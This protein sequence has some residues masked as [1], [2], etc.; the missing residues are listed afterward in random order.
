MK[1]FTLAVCIA[2][3]C[4]ASDASAQDRTLVLQG[5]T[6]I[7]GTGRAP[8]TDA[9]VVVENGRI[10]SVGRRGQM[11]IPAG[12]QIIDTTGQTILPG[13]VD[14]HLHLR[15]WKIPF[16]PLYGVV[17]TGDIHNDTQWILGQKALLKSGFMKGPRLF[18]SGARING[19]NG[20]PLK[21]STGKIV[22]DPS[23]VKTPDEARA[24]VRYLH[25]AGVDFLKVDYS[26]TEDQLKAIIDEASKYNLPVLGH[27]NNVDTAMNYGGKEIEHMAGIFRAQMIREG[28]TP[29]ASNG[30]ALAAGVDP[31]KF[32]PLIQRMVEQNVALDIALYWTVKP[33]VWDIMRPEVA[34]L[35]NDPA[36]AFV[37]AEE[38]KL[39]LQ[40]PAKPNPVEDAATI[41][42]L[43]QFAAAGGHFTI[44]TD[45]NEKSDVPPGLGTHII[46]EGV[47][48][49]GMPKM[50]IIQAI[51]LWPAQAMGIDRDYGS[52]E[53]GKHGDFVIVQGDPLADIKAARNIKMVIMGGKVMD[54]KLDPN[55][56]NPLPRPASAMDP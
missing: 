10:F 13:L 36:T 11:T 27:I 56:V 49:L 1:R 15:G 16:Y 41:T 50:K 18:V 9:V 37:P 14:M 47:A 33:L 17:T 34:R 35:A 53:P 44:D 21:D 6:L 31:K 48:K 51:T 4:I 40:D 38:K 45:G 12:A 25:A 42:F 23:N 5:G 52:V 54:T 20:G 30:A 32:G 29:P 24:Y 8:I 46:M 7:D 55:F 43:N 3:L 19:P 2:A 22:E 28:K 26:V 39:W